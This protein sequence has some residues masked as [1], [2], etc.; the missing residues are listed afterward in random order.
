M[1]Q[2]SSI[3]FSL[4]HNIPSLSAI[5]SR[6]FRSYVFLLISTIFIYC[7]SQNLQNFFI[8]FFISLY[9]LK[10]LFI[11]TN[12]TWLICESIKALEIGTSIIFNLSFPTQPVIVEARI[13]KCKSPSRWIPPC[14]SEGD[15][16]PRSSKQSAST[17]R[18]QLSDAAK[19]VRSTDLLNHVKA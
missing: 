11:E 13:S 18:A 17:R 8:S 14:C 12:S 7:I 3:R 1:I 9:S 5:V 10:T 6:P 16:S 19:A 2:S 15:Y 4:N